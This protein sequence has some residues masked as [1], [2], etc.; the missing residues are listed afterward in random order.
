MQLYQ[1]K[2]RH[3]M[4]KTCRELV[5]M[6]VSTFA[7]HSIG[8]D[9]SDLSFRITLVQWSIWKKSE[10]F[11]PQLHNVYYNLRK[12]IFMW[13]S[14]YIILFF[15]PRKTWK[16]SHKAPKILKKYVYVHSVRFMKFK[17]I[18]KQDQPRARM[19]FIIYVWYVVFAFLVILHV[20]RKL[21]LI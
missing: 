4:S 14:C 12:M 1:C 3:L 20:L 10:S 6:R 18:W 15:R 13:D 8:Y 9:D 21:F 17:I 5:H 2:W 19:C 11:N 7:R 16:K